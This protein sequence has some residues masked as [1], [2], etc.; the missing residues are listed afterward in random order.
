MALMVK[1]LRTG[2]SQEVGC[3]GEVPGPRLGGWRWSTMGITA[4]DPYVGEGLCEPPGQGLLCF[5]L[6]GSDP[7]LPASLSSTG[8]QGCVSS[9]L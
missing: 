1:K 6:P 7:Q 9:W 5:L 2:P 4:R 8:G 3:L